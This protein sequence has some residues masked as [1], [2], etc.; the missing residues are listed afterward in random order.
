MA[1]NNNGGFIVIWQSNMQDGSGY[2]I[3]GQKFDNKGNPFG[4]EFIINDVGKGSQEFPKVSMNTKGN[5]IIVWKSNQNNNNSFEPGAEKFSDIYA[6]KY[7]SNGSPEGGEFVV[8]TTIGEQWLP[9]VSLNENNDFV[10]TWNLREKDTDNYEI[11]A[12]YYT[13]GVPQ[14]PAFK[15]SSTKAD[16][17]SHPNTA[18]DSKGNFVIVWNGVIGSLLSSGVFGRKFAFDGSEIES[19]FKINSAGKTAIQPD[20]TFDKSGNYTVIWREY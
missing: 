4:S 19:E 5:Y 10:I 16:R 7:N 9:S 11:Y 1:I 12:R 17:L 14:R 15:V 3:V 18:I 2:G 20:I 6:K 8:S 13:N